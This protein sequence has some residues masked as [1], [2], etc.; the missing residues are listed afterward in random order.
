ME[1]RLEN[2]YG[3]D[4]FVSV[5]AETARKNGCLCIHE[6]NGQKVTC[7]HFKANM[8]YEET[9]RER[10]GDDYRGHLKTRAVEEFTF[11]RVTGKPFAHDGACRMAM[12]NFLVCVIGNIAMAITRCPEY[13]APTEAA[14]KPKNHGRCIP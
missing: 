3:K 11:F 2:H 1:I 12:A 8:Q 9:L 4:V 14:D 5:Q 6:E 13:E 10:F 7:E